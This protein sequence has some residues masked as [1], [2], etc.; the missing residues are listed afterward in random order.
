MITNRARR[1]VGAGLAL[2]A[3][4]LVPATAPAE[5]VLPTGFTA[6]VYVTGEGFGGA[7]GFRGRGIPTTPTLAVDRAGVLYLARSGRRYSG[8]EFDYL[9]FIYRIEPGGAELTPATEPRYFYGAPLNNAQVSGGRRGRELFVTT[10][11]RDRRIGVLY[12][13]VDGRV[14][15][16]A[17]GTPDA[18]RPPIL[19]QPEGAAVDS[20]G[21]VY[22][23]DRARGVVLRFDSTGRVLDSS[24]VRVIRPR[25]LT[26]DEADHLWVGSDGTAEA[27]WQAGPGALWRV[28]PG[29]A[30]RLMVEGP[31]AQGLTPGP[32]GSVFVADRHGNEIFGVI[33]DG[34]R[35]S[36]ARFTNGDAPRGLAFVPDTAET[37]AAGLAGD[38]LVS[39]IRTGVFQLNQIVRISGPF[40]DLAQRR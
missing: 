13:L 25:T 36:L 37:R 20:A 2:V 17:G 39:I 23:A 22:V 33:A 3:G 14:Q 1:G 18:G 34:S 21:N 11:D 12:R 10:F 7:T 38:L 8:G 30:R 6:R 9:S 24:Y 16:F 29:G 26:V 31:V 4:L 19:I 15:L 35:V 28:A 32:V 27:P 5:I 40:A